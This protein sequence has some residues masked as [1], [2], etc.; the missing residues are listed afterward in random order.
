MRNKGPTQ[1]RIIGGQWKRTPLRVI[2]AQGLRPTPDR[3]RETVFNWLG[4][5]VVGAQ[6]LDLFAGTG[7]LGFEAASRGAASVEFVEA[8]LAARAQLLATKT[9]LQASQIEV[10]GTD[11]LLA[12]KVLQARGRSFDVVFLDPPFGQDWSQR[13]LPLLVA[14]LKPGAWVY[15]ESESAFGAS[16]QAQ[17]WQLLKSAKAGQVH[18]HWLQFNPSKELTCQP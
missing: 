10:V 6:C 15:L 7:A 5:K 18:Y 1:V 8:N 3:V 2:D 17:G 9:K 4:D 11:A 12:L 13:V 14:I 16:E